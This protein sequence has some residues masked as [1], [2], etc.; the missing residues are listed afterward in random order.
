MLLGMRSLY[1]GATYWLA[2]RLCPP[3]KVPASRVESIPV[4]SDQT[5]KNA[6]PVA[7]RYRRDN[8]RAVSICDSSENPP[9]CAQEAARTAAAGAAPQVQPKYCSIA[10][11]PR[12]P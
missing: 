7:L 11:V 10:R 5:S 8:H 9:S 6:K 1:S 12:L 2:P 3:S 4:L